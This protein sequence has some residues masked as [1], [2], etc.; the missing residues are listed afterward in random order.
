MEFA[1]RLGVLALIMT[2]VGLGIT[3]LWPTKRWIGWISLGIALFLGGW[4]GWL[5]W[6]KSHHKAEP[7]QVVNAE[8]STNPQVPLKELQDIKDALNEIE[9]NTRE[10][11]R[12]TT[13][14]DK[15]TIRVEARTTIYGYF[16]RYAHYRD[17]R[18]YWSMPQPAPEMISREYSNFEK[19]YRASFKDKLLRIRQTLIGNIDHLPSRRWD[20]EETYNL[21]EGLLQDVTV[22]HQFQDFCALLNEFEKENNFA[23]SCTE[24]RGV[25]HFSD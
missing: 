21:P 2:F 24:L 10:Q 14:S 22:E 16:E 20:V 3:I 13:S 5:E 9:K 6:A 7:A 19:D 17:R 4:W 1:D 8:P 11:V 12:P 25:L 23:P 18:F 15:G